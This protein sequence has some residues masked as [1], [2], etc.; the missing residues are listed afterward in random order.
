MG[1]LTVAAASFAPAASAFTFTPEQLADGEAY[2]GRDCS[3]CHGSPELVVERA[4]GDT[5]LQKTVWMTPFLARHHAPDQSTRTL[6]IGYLE[7][8]GSR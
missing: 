4:P 5:I 2:Y 8:V 1:I 6:I 3:S 7:S